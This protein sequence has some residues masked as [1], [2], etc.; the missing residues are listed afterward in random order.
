[1]GR[2]LLLALSIPHV[3]FKYQYKSTENRLLRKISKIKNQILKNVGE[4]R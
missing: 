1:M 3:R 4:S 2:N